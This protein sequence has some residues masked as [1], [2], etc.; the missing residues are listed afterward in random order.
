MS[1]LRN[2]WYEAKAIYHRYPER[3]TGGVGFVAGL[4]IGAQL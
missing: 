1:K 2:A 4:L 3:V